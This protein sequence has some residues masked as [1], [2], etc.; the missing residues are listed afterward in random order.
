M[1]SLR[2]CRSLCALRSMCPVP[3]DLCPVAATVPCRSLC[4]VLFAAYA[5]CY[6]SYGAHSLPVPCALCPVA[7]TVPIRSLCPAAAT[8]PI[9]SLRPVPCRSYGALSQLRAHS[10]PVPGDSL[11]LLQPLSQPLCL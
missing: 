8:V 6:P 5:L 9:R 1:A 4:P 7:A 2:A 3:C 11:F 10:Q